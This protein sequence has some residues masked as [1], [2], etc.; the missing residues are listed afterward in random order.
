MT[1]P[2][3]PMI[4]YGDEVGMW[5]GDDPDCRKPMI[6]KNIKFDPERYNAFGAE[7]MPDKVS[8]NKDLFNRYKKLIKIRKDNKVLSEGNLGFFYLND[9]DKV[10]GYKRT[11]GNESVFVLIN[12]NNI[13]KSL[14]IKTKLFNDSAII[15]DLSTGKKIKAKNNTYKIDMLPYQ[16]MM[17]INE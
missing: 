14:E 2:G 16:L 17:L 13:K 3:A 12:N 9:S 7:H 1:M 6:W 10:L 5:G 8:F 15:S 11:L 4:Y